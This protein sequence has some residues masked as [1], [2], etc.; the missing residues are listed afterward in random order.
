[1][2]FGDRD[3]V[4]T[5]ASDVTSDAMLLEL[6]DV[7]RTARRSGLSFVTQLPNKSLQATC[8]RASFRSRLQPGRTR[9]SLVV[10][11]P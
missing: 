8:G 11:Q 5:L 9:L 3:Y 7:T 4:I 6:D 10:G 2:K 1:M